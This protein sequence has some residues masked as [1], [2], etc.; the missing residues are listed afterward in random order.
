MSIRSKNSK[1]IILMSIAIAIG[2]FVDGLFANSLGITMLIALLA[3]CDGIH[4][5]SY[6][7]D[8]ND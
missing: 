4:H 3:H 8:F 1:I 2:I 6:R 7:K 5:D